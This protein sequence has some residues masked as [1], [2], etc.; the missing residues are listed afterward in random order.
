MYDLIT[1]L[2]KRKIQLGEGYTVIKYVSSLYGNEFFN[3]VD[4]T[5]VVG[6]GISHRRVGNLAWR[7]FFVSFQRTRRGFYSIL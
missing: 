4:V 3:A 2:M 6:I 5:F 1:R 7:G